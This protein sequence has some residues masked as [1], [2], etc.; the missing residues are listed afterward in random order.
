MKFKVGDHVVIVVP[1][2]HYKSWA[3]TVGTVVQ[4]LNARGRDTLYRL[5]LDGFERNFWEDELE[6]SVLD[7]LAKVVS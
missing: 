7:E 6:L 1:A 5:R 3:G 2:G 4:V